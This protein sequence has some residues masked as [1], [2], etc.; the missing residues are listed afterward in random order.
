MTKLNAKHM[1]AAVNDLR[2]AGFTIVPTESVDPEAKNLARRLF[3]HATIK[4]MMRGVALDDDR[5]GK[6]RDE[7]IRAIHAAYYDVLARQSA[8]QSEP[9]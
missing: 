3:S 7:A 5:L 9:R 2:A 6:A 1:L 8:R 4:L